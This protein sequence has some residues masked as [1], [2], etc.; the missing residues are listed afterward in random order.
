MNKRK[1]I[2]YVV[3]YFQSN[4]GYKIEY[5]FDIFVDY[6]DVYKWTRAK[7]GE[8]VY[9][10]ISL[11]SARALWRDLKKL[12]FNINGKLQGMEQ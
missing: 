1:K 8:K 6:A 12:G 3:K 7:G 9:S 4:V 10:R 5:R 11:H 2:W